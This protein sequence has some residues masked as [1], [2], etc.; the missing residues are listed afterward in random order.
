MLEP[1]TPNRQSPQPPGNRKIK[2]TIAYDGSGYHGW[3]RQ[4]DGIETV[5]QVMEQAI[6]RL[7]KHPMSLR[8]SGRT[9]TGVHAAAQVACFRTNSPIPESRFPHA[10]NS[11]LPR[12]I[13]VVNAQLVDGG[14]DAI[15]SAQSKLYRYTVFNH[16]NMP[17]QADRYCYHYYIPCK[18]APMQ[19]A[20]DMLI[21]EHDFASFA[22]SG[23]ERQTTVRRLLRCHV[24]RQ[25]DWLY[26][27]LEATGF[28]YHMVRN[29][30]GT[31]LEIG[32]GYWPP[33]QITDI[34]AARDRSAAGPMVPAN[35]LCLQWVRYRSHRVATSNDQAP[36]VEPC[37]PAREGSL[38]QEEKT[39]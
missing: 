22:A 15:L 26:F 7:V 32:R 9:D 39:R 8:A 25:Y 2:L 21:G 38:S 33:E 12:E 30:V 11:R 6:A 1:E 18:L 23:H 31:L 37:R 28:L 10:I 36:I 5:Q 34:L 24:W 19:A 35:G 27:D 29:I 13:R 14:F 16:T 3:Q 4:A 17:P 20:A